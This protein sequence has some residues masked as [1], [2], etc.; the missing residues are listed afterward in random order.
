MILSVDNLCIQGFWHGPFTTMERLCVRSFLANGHDFYLYAY[1]DIKGLPVGTH[2]MDANEIVPESQVSLF[3][4]STH[5][6]DFFRV[7]LLLKKGGWHSDLDNVCLKPL[8][9]AAEYCFYRDQEES[10][11]SLALSKCP[12]NSP[13]M[14]H[15]YDYIRSM[16]QDERE[17]LSWQAIGPGFTCGAIEYFGLAQYAQPGYV[18]DPVH[19]SNARRLIDPAFQPDLSQSYSLHLFHAAW[20]QGPQDRYGAGW[21]LGQ[22]SGEQISTDGEYHSD[23]LYEKLKRRYL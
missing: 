11:I 3:R 19:W 5:F 22:P 1:D 15:C 7:A 16:P 4:C 12:S 23:C 2:I 13:L 6:S 20:N 14:A 8:D 9:F 17:R 18:F 21:D 10:T